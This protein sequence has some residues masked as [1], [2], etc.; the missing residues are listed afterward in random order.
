VALAPPLDAEVGA[1][2]VEDTGD[3]TDEDDFKVLIVGAGDGRDRCDCTATIFEG[4]C[5]EGDMD[6]DELPKSRNSHFSDLRTTSGP[7]KG[8]RSRTRTSTF[9]PASFRGFVGSES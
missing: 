2:D 6:S 7:S 5:W 8:V 3:F 9:P 4:C 1:E